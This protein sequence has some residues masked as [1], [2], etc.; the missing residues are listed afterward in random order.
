[1]NID[2]TDGGEH[3]FVFGTQVQ[4][5]LDEHKHSLRNTEFWKDQLSTYALK[6][7]GVSPEEDTGKNGSR[8]RIKTKAKGNSK[9][10]EKK[11][12]QSQTKKQRRFGS[13]N[14]ET[15]R[16]SKGGEV[17]C[18]GDE[19]VN[20]MEELLYRKED[21]NSTHDM[22]INSLKREG[23]IVDNIIAKDKIINGYAGSRRLELSESNTKLTQR[24]SSYPE[25]FTPSDLG[26]LY[27]LT[28]S[29]MNLEQQEQMGESADNEDSNGMQDYTGMI[30]GVFT[31]SQVLGENTQRTA[32]T[33]KSDYECIVIEDSCGSGRDEEDGENPEITFEYIEK[34]KD[35]NEVRGTQDVPIEID[36][37]HRACELIEIPNSSDEDHEEEYGTIFDVLGGAANGGEVSI[38]EIA[39]SSACEESVNDIVITKQPDEGTQRVEEYI[40][41]TN[42]IIPTSSPIGSQVEMPDMLLES[43]DG[44]SRIVITKPM[45]EEGIDQEGAVGGIDFIPDSEDEA[46]GADDVVISAEFLTAPTQP[47]PETNVPDKDGE[48]MKYYEGWNVS[49]L[50]KQLNIWGIK[51]VSKMSKKSLQASIEKV[52]VNVEEGKWLEAVSRA[53]TGE[54]IEFANDVEIEAEEDVAS[55]LFKRVVSIL[56]WD[57]EVRYD[58]L[59]YIPI[60]A[61]RIISKINKGDQEELAVDRRIDKKII[62]DILDKLGICWTDVE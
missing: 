27:D 5:G 43:C 58:V 25:D 21:W 40:A 23:S 3:L 37:G 44:G 1:M 45:E 9:P 10:R 13:I 8:R 22:L 55:V 31:L 16:I 60:N 35:E 34:L 47:E 62:C 57:D 51:Q 33:Q 4:A 2:N 6:T 14:R 48:R 41:D 61:S 20:D 11:A 19:A 56:Q 15:I 53:K 12:S 32:E 7:D 36:S 46:D 39:N 28:V 50:K 24:S 26:A 18:K 29:N 42:T 54:P 38:L 17:G 52:C 49:M 59:R 30:S